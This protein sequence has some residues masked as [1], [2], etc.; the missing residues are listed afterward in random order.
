[1]TNPILTEASLVV[2]LGLLIFHASNCFAW[3]IS[4]ASVSLMPA[5]INDFY[6]APPADTN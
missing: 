2:L 1:M 4:A 6:L 3:S 5:L